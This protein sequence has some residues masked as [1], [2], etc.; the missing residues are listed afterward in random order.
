[1]KN[2]FLVLFI[3]INTVW[4]EGC[5]QIFGKYNDD[6]CFSIHQTTDGGYL[7]TGYT[8]SFGNCLTTD[9]WLI[10]TDSV[11]VEK[12]NQTFT[13]SITA[14]DQH[15]YVQQTINGGYIITGETTRNEIVNVWL[16]KIDSIGNKEWNQ[17][18]G[19][20]SDDGRGYVQRTTDSG[21]IITGN[22]SSFGDGEKDIW[23]I[24]TD[25]NGK[26]KWSQTFDGGDSDIYRSVHQ[27]TDGG[28]II[29]GWTYS[30]ENDSSDVWLIKTDFDGNKLW[31]QTFGG[32]L[33]GEGI[34]VLMTKDGGYI[35]TSYTHP[36]GNGEEKFW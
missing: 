1:M 33:N 11:G 27:T 35:I 13:D 9:V 24:K 4:E 7:M 21:Y 15:S 23:L 29:A 30:F 19:G 25:S 22:I 5:A 8:I 18:S 16:T 6:F 28:Y 2:I 34:S 3:I 10:K 31:N 20:I 17:T 32:Q 36:L 26:E 12:W 14:E